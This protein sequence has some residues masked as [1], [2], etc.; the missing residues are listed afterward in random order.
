MGKDLGK[1][2]QRGFYI[3]LGATATLLEIAQDS[4]NQTATIESLSQDLG[5]LTQELVDK[6]VTT[7]AEARSFVDRFVS[8]NMQGKGSDLD[9]RTV[10]TTAFDITAVGT[11]DSLENFAAQN[12]V[13]DLTKLLAELRLELESLR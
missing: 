9:Q 4:R 12:E 13:R 7:E 11:V 5:L 2:L 3:T 10:N 8:Q 6:G 1:V